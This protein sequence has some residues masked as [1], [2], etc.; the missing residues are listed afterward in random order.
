M[1]SLDDLKAAVAKL[2]ADETALI[3]FVG[4]QSTS[5]T[6]LTTQ[7]ASLQATI[8]AGNAINPAD[9]EAIAAELNTMDASITAVLPKPEAPAAAV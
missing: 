6:A 9:I 4:Q 8:A 7:V 2:Q 1:A 5:V 3:N